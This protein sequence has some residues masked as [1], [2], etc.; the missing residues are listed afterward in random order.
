MISEVNIIYNIYYSHITK[1]IQKIDFIGNQIDNKNRT[2]EILCRIGN[3]IYNNKSCLAL[4][5]DNT[6]SIKILN[7]SSYKSIFNKNDWKDYK[8]MLTI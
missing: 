4:S 7:I 8:S 2:W 5:D 6:N 3:V 1:K